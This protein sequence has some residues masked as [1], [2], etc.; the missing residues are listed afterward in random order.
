MTTTVT[1]TALARLS[2]DHRRN[3]VEL[4]DAIETLTK[5]TDALNLIAAVWADDDDP[6][7]TPEDASLATD[8]RA[9]IARL[10]RVLDM[11]HPTV[12]AI[13]ASQ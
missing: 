5:D 13:E 7:L 3:L 4:A 10:T 9:F 1:R 2:P 12:D 6:H 8:R 11:L